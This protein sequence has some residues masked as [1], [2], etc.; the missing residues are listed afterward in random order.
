LNI[1]IQRGERV[2]ILASNG[3]AKVAL[4]KAT[5]GLF[6]HGGGR[7][8]RPTANQ[9]L[10][11]PEHPYLPKG[12]L[13][14]L[15]GGTPQAGTAADDAIENA[16]RALGLESVLGR[17]RGP[18]TDQDWNELLSPAEQTLIEVARVLLAAP[19]FV[20]LD[21]LLGSLDPAEVDRVYQAFVKRGITYIVLGRADDDLNSFDKV[22]TI[23]ED[24]AWQWKCRD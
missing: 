6:Q 7:I 22:L 9:M 2:L 8:V 14:E 20:F 3:F 21:R 5:A 15:L 11:L 19:E 24:G 12:T 13:R 18:D 1:T 4:F 17:A 10:F 16:L 23:T